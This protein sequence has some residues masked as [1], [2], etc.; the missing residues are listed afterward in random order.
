LFGGKWETRPITVAA[1]AAAT[2]TNVATALKALPNAVIPTVTVAA[3]AANAAAALPIGFG[4][5]ITVTF[6][7]EANSGAQNLL[8]VNYKGCNRAG[9]APLYTGLTSTDNGVTVTV[10]DTTT[11]A[12]GYSYQEKSIC[13]EHGLCDSATGLCKC[14]HGYYNLDCSDQT[15]LV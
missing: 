10:A 8:T 1:T 15:I 3:A 2:A 5:C 11:L 13:S 7:D 12:T 4:T 9:C 14:F 6:I